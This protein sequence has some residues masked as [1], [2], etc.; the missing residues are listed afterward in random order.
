MTGPAYTLCGMP[1]HA[2]SAGGFVFAGAAVKVKWN[3]APRPPL[4]LAQIRPPCDS[5]IDLLIARPMPLPCGFVVKNASN[6]WSGL[7]GGSPGLMDQVKA[8]LPKFEDN[9]NRKANSVENPLPMPYGPA[10]AVDQA[11]FA[12]MMKRM[13]VAVGGVPPEAELHD[14]FLPGPDGSVGARN[15][16]PEA[17]SAVS[18][19]YQRFT[20]PIPLPILAIMGYPQNKGLN[21]HAKIPKNI[22]AAAAADA[23][24]CVRLTH[25]KEASQLRM[26]SASRMPTTTSSFQMKPRS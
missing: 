11:S 17:G 15:A 2:A 4:P 6:I 26:S 22:A 8:E 14:S 19:G 24:K 9:L 7:P 21:F 10:S 3:V 23:T 12:A 18:K 20:T 16:S 5:T 1:N 13:T 25:L